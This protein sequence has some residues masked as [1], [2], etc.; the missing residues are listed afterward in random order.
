[1]KGFASE[2]QAPLRAADVLIDGRRPASELQVL[3]VVGKIRQTDPGPA[4][5][6]GS[7]A[8]PA[9]ARHRA[10]AANLELIR[11]ITFGPVSRNRNH[12]SSITREL[13]LEDAKY[14]ALRELR[15]GTEPR[16]ASGGLCE[17]GNPSGAAEALLGDRRRL[18]RP[19]GVTRTV[20][21]VPAFLNERPALLR[22]RAWR[23]GCREGVDQGVSMDRP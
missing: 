21:S 12:R 19:P 1:M 17:D 3:A 14:D 20:A 11:R 15:A 9:K 16:R 10:S 7:S 13:S 8:A 18:R 2:R 5:R 23:C 6:A 4:P 22:P